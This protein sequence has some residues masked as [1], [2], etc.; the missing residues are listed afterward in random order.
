MWVRF[1]HLQLSRVQ[2]PKIS[3]RHFIH[4]M[5]KNKGNYQ[6]Y[7]IDLNQIYCVLFERVVGIYISEGS[8]GEAVQLKTRVLHSFQDITLLTQFNWGIFSHGFP[9]PPS[10]SR[11]QERFSSFFP[12]CS[13]HLFHPRFSKKR[14]QI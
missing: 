1:V 3:Y 2:L 12:R 14:N 11:W 6:Q 5:F 4:D 10:F 7:F 9:Q 8:K 13:L